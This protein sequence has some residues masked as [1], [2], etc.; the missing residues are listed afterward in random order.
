MKCKGW[1]GPCERHDATR[2]RQ[3]TRYVED[4]R[5]WVI[6]C[7]KC[8]EENEKYWKQMWL[9]YHYDCL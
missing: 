5:N 8:M 7:P 4:D 6:L 1:E 9:D 3:N 2:H